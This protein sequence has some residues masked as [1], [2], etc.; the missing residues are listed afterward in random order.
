MPY[1]GDVIADLIL[2]LNSMI[3]IVI[4]VLVALC[5]AQKIC[6]FKHHDLHSENVFVKFCKVQEE[7]PLPDGSSIRVPDTGVQ[8]VIADYG[9]SAIT[10]ENKRF[11]RADTEDLKVDNGKWGAWNSILQGNEGYDMAV[12]LHNLQADCEEPANRIFL[13]SLEAAAKSLK[14]Y[15]M[16]SYGRPYGKVGVTML[17]LLHH[18][19]FQ[20]CISS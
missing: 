6:H 16:S 20:C 13:D 2:P 12:F 7:W 19:I 14:F 9:Q 18:P 11:S 8:A 4:Q 1:A 3:S 5:W 10:R 15:R 17:N